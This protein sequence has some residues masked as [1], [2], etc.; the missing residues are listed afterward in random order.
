M[1]SRRRL[2]LG[3][4]WALRQHARATR[5]SELDTLAFPLLAALGLLSSL[6]QVTTWLGSSGKGP[7]TRSG[8]SQTHLSCRHKNACLGLKRLQS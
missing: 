4:K 7:K 3:L 2:A 8:V 5:I 1:A 6:T